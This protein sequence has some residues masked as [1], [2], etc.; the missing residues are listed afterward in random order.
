MLLVVGDGPLRQQVEQAAGPLVRIV[1][2]RL[3]VSRLL[4]ASDFFV[5]VSRREG[6]AFGI[7]E[8]MAHGL[9]AVVTNLPENTE[10]IGETGIAVPWG[11]ER[12]LAASF[13]RLATQKQERQVLGQQARRRLVTCFD[14]AKMIA[15]TRAIYSGLADTPRLT[16]HE[17]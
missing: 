14:A 17:L 13:R 6:F 2:H 7:L 15:H 3:D 1:G 8:A 4:E 5:L 16:S 11:D 12:L 10:A 9:P